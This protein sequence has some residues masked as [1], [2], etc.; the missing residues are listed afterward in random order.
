MVT[1][2]AA[3]APATVARSPSAWNC[4][5][6]AIGATRI[7]ANSVWPNSVRL[8][9]QIEH[10]H[11]HPR[12]KRDPIERRPVAA[13]NC[14]VGIA[15]QDARRLLFVFQDVDQLVARREP[16]ARLG[17][18]PLR[19]R[20]GVDDDGPEAAQGLT[21]RNRPLLHMSFSRDAIIL[22]LFFFFVS[23]RERR[24]FVVAFVLPP[25]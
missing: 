6:S 17:P 19:A 23:F 18:W 11:H 12:S 1:A 24:V 9:I 10:R 15:G 7:G 5:C 2:L 25:G 3:E 16:Y 8:E 21:P 14:R 4:A 13:G 22:S 20:H